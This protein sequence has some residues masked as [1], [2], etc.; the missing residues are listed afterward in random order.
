MKSLYFDVSVARILATKA[1]GRF[2]PAVYF[3]SLSPVRFGELPEQKLPGPNWVRVKPRLA[4]ICGADLS[5]FFVKASPSI[6][7][8][9]LPGIPRVFMGHELVGMV[10]ETGSGVKDLKLGDRV[11]LQRYLPCCS[12][13]EIDP[14]CAPCQAGNYNLCENFSVKRMPENLGAG[15]SEQFIA[16]ASQL[17][18]VPDA[19]SDEQAVLIE[20][21]SVSLH[22]VLRRPPGEGEQVLVIGAGTIGLNIIQ[23]ARAL[24]PGCVIHVLEKIAF[25]K[26]LACKLGADAVLEGDPYDAAAKATGGKVY[27]GLLKNTTMLGGFDLIYDCVGYN[28]TVHDALR[29]LKS[30]GTYVMVGNLLTPITFDHTPL[31][32]QELTVLGVN[33]H[34]M[35][36][37]QGDSL[38]SFA[39]AMEMI[40]QGRISLDGFITQ[41]FALDDYREAFQLVRDKPG[42]VI[43]VIFEIRK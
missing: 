28:A 11:T 8:A 35:E 37:Y 13:L 17:L 38:S 26:D 18:K 6:S 7:I 15:F 12:M 21:A 39:L 30:H 3:S 25:K 10:I 23:F 1:L 36:N 40:E 27:R 31:W 14:P 34:G 32:N 22:A 41:R 20:P 5:L 43:K 19:I 4:G 2:L 9:A 29:W 24:S 42:R 16:H 33:A